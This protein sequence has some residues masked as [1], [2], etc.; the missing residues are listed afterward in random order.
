MLSVSVFGIAKIGQGARLVDDAE[1]GSEGRGAQLV[2]DAEPGSD[3]PESGSPTTSCI[4]MAG[5]LESLKCIS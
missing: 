5:E 3:G 2:D 4:S 1:P